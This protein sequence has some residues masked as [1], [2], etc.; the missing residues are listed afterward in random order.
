M[1]INLSS[2]VDAAHAAGI[3][4]YEI[5]MVAAKVKAAGA[6]EIKEK[7][8]GWLAIATRAQL[9]NAA[10]VLTAQAWQRRASRKRR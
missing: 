6:G 3:T 9:L 4:Q 2:A 8:A 7:P 10:A 1:P 5:E